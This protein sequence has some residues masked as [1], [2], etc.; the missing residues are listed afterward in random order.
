MSVK[1][2]KLKKK[3]NEVLFAEEVVSQHIILSLPLNSDDALNEL[4]SDYI[5]LSKVMA[6]L[7]NTDKMV[8]TIYY[9][10]G[11]FEIVARFDYKSHFRASKELYCT[12]TYHSFEAAY[13]LFFNNL[14]S[15]KSCN[16]NIIPRYPKGVTNETLSSK[17]FGGKMFF[18]L[19]KVT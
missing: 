12:F 11:G 14:L 10:N 16:I 1:K 8:V 17:G 7:P 6:E 19:K 18:V 13:C 3:S 2:F 15:L 4:E 5:A 9:T